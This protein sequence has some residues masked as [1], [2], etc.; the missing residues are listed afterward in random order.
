M[1]ERTQ[2]AVTIGDV[3]RLALPLSTTVVSGT[4]YGRKKINWVT[5]LSSWG[6]VDSD[7]RV[8]DL[9]LLPSP[10]PAMMNEG[11]L[12]QGVERLVAIGIAGIIAFE[13]LPKVATLAARTHNLVV[14]IMPANYSPRDIHQSISSLL[15][16]RQKQTTE[17]GMQLYRRLSELSREGH[18]LNAMTEIMSQ[19]TGKTVVV[20]DKRL[21]I[22]AI[23][24]PLNSTTDKEHLSAIL[25]KREQLPSDLRNRKTV[26]KSNQN[27]WQQVL[28]IQESGAELAR[29]IAP[30]I[31]GDR[32]RGYVSVIG[33]ANEL[34]LLDTL[35]VEHGAAACAL[36]MAKAKAISEA[37]KGLRGDF[38][39]GLLTGK[40]PKEE[41]ER[42]ESRLDHDTKRDHVVLVMS[43]DE[44]AEVVPSLRR[45][46][47]AVN[48]LLTTHNR[49]I[50]AH[51]YGS[52][53]FCLFQGMNL[54]D[55][56]DKASVFEL[57]KRIR[58]HVE[59]EHKGARLMVGISGLAHTI[60]DWAEN[61]RRAVQAMRLAQRL[62]LNHTVDY[63]SLG[64]YQLLTELEDFPAVQM[65]AEKTVGALA[66]YD[67]KHR[68]SLVKT[69][70]AYFEHHG[71]ISQTAESLF[72]HRNTLLYRLE[73]IQDLTGQNLEQ[74]DMRL[75]LHL[76]LK[77]WQ[78]RGSVS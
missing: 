61:H 19:L 31:S 40:F 17:R 52:T 65:F 46:E 73:R 14:L 38:L 10:V 36:E 29:L 8:G 11:V 30:I 6:R 59:V 58:E 49:P 71:N 2:E 57:V 7:V 63:S 27:H 4:D 16:D 69:L 56:Q 74:A 76:S 37:K 9:V 42:L 68:S 35:T 44:S 55:G 60:H 64:I 50:L 33:L 1:L 41:I 22:K 77:L 45:L 43:W 13:H 5:F 34:D 20:Q 25:E 39:E 12:R 26:A 48:W 32:A 3:I 15:I 75:A 21:E 62:Q 67:D 72:I 54:T 78:L 24:L 23:S 51:M 18:G 70:L 28:P 47:T 66:D 53:H